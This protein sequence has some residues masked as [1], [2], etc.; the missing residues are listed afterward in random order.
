MFS[1]D[2]THSSKNPDFNSSRTAYCPN[3]D[4]QIE[5]ASLAFDISFITVSLAYTYPTR[6]PLSGIF[7]E[8]EEM[9]IYFS[10]TICRRFVLPLHSVYLRSS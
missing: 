4:A 7:F 9:M 1:K 10:F 3:E 2:E 6:N 5:M 8:K